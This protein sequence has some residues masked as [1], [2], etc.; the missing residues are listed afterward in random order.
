MKTM[1]ENNTIYIPDYH[2]DDIAVNMELTDQ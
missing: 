1:T 2:D